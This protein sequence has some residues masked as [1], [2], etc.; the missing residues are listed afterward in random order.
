MYREAIHAYALIPHASNAETHIGQSDQADDVDS[1][2]GRIDDSI[3]PLE[4]LSRFC[5]PSPKSIP[6]CDGSKRLECLLSRRLGL[7]RDIVLVFSVGQLLLGE[8]KY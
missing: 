3:R 7:S 5:V 4:L 6:V 1:M 2:L 8:L